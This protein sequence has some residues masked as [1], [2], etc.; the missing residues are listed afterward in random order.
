MDTVK[1]IQEKIDDREDALK[2]I[3]EMEPIDRTD[4]V[5]AEQC[6]LEDE[7]SK[8]KAKRDKL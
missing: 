6:N 4:Y 7:I 1:S 3:K 5:N 2:H 8:L